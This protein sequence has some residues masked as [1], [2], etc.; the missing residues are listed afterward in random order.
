MKHTA[1]AVV[2]W[3]ALFSSLTATAKDDGRY[4]G[5]ALKSWFDQLGSGKGLCCSVA[6]GRSVADPDWGTEAVAGA[7]GKSTIAFWVKV[8]GKK[9]DVPPDAVVSEPNTYGPAVVWPVIG[10]D[11]ATQIRCFLPGAEG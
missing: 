5:S 10:P 2:L 8:D 11:G 1:A 3:C 6:D 7:A 4:A 9:I